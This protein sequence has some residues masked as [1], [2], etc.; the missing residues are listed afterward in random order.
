MKGIEISKAFY[1]Q[2]GKDLIHEKCPDL[3]AKLAIGL[4]G[5]GS[6]CYGFDDDYSTDHDFEPGFCI[7]IPDNFTSKEEFRLEHLYNELPT[8]FMGLKRHKLLPGENTKYG[9]IRINDFYLNKIGY[10][11]TIPSLVD[12][13]KVP[14]FFLLE[15]TNGEVFRDDLGTFSSIRSNLSFY[16]KDVLLKKLAG[17]LLLIYQSGV[18]N[19]KRCYNRSDLGAAQLSVIEFVKHAIEVI[20]LLNKKYTPY[21]KWMFR[22]LRELKDLS[23]FE[24][25]L[26][27]LISS[28]NTK[29]DFLNKSKL[30]EEIIFEIIKVLKEKNYIPNSLTDLDIIAFSLNDSIED[31][32]LRN[33]NILFGTK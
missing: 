31:D 2:Y 9:V 23:H 7:F 14:S 12:W 20:Y 15:A 24:K 8:E 22:G 10:S 29:I 28:N 27:Y 19:Y 11:T 25:D 18:Y 30:I 13:L 4:V 32:N 17:E 16:P 1:Q 21:Y 6:E 26:I 5:S 33:L 3:E